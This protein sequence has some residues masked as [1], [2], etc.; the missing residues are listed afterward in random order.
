MR[1]I[2]FKVITSL[3]LCVGI[4]CNSNAQVKTKIFN[5]GIPDQSIPINQFLFLKK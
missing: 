3:L 1:Q 4:I 5:E 2:N